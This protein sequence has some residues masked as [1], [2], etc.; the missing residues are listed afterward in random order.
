MYA[1]IAIIVLVVLVWVFR[2]QMN[3]IYKSLMGIIKGAT[4]GSED[5][6]EIIEELSKKQ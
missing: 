2:K 6:G 1:I 3:E 5:A 4:A